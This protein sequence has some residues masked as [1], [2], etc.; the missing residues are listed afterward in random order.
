M[1]LSCTTT[2][3]VFSARPTL[4]NEKMSKT[5]TI[6]DVHDHDLLA[7]ETTATA[8]TI[9]SMSPRNVA[10]ITMVETIMEKVVVTT[11]YISSRTVAKMTAVIGQTILA[12]RQSVRLIRTTTYICEI[13]N[14]IMK[15]T[16]QTIYALKT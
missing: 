3:I 11:T 10:R 12:S 16:V 13:L 15:N 14:L 7:A 1:P 6:D 4:K 8:W 2:R 5:E 9:I